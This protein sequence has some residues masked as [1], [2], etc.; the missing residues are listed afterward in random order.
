[1]PDPPQQKS[2]G[3]ARTPVYPSGDEQDRSIFIKQI[4]SCT[5]PRKEV[6]ILC[7]RIHNITGQEHFPS[8]L[9]THRKQTIAMSYQCSKGPTAREIKRGEA[10]IA[11]A[12]NTSVTPS[13]QG[14]RLFQSDPPL[15]PAIP[16]F[17]TLI[18]MVEQTLS[19]ERP[20]LADET[21]LSVIPNNVIADITDQIKLHKKV[22]I[23]VNIGPPGGLDSVRRTYGAVLR[24]STLLLE[25]QRP[26][27]MGIF[28]KLVIDVSNAIAL[29]QATKEE[30]VSLTKRYFVEL[31]TA[32]A[33][34]MELS[35]LAS[36][37][38]GKEPSGVDAFVRVREKVWG[39]VRISPS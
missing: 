20:T 36:F 2:A 18:Y 23:C 37:A 19:L 12:N 26:A 32:K 29:K 30:S 28:G 34:L 35:A 1:M 14:N 31:I 4:E 13:L 38:L 39:K 3:T 27:D 8:F 15:P 5:D 25:K 10:V 7:T 16:E 11:A 6:S 21:I 33:P 24:Q 9:P 22:F 17:D